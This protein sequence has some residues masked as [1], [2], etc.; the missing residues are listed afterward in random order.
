MFKGTVA[1]LVIL[2]VWGAFILGGLPLVGVDHMGLLAGLVVGIGVGAA[3]MTGQLMGAHR[4]RRE[5]VVDE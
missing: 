5:D 2:A 4:V 1:D 3:Y